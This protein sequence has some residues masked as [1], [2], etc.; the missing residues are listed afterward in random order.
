MAYFAIQVR[1][2]T[3]GRF[4]ALAQKKGF[5][6]PDAR[7]LWPRRRLRIRRAGAWLDSLAA[8]FPGYLFIQVDGIP[9]EL[10]SALRGTAGFLRFLRSNDDI[11]PMNRRDEDV[12]AHFLGF[13]EVVDRSVVF[14]DENRK[15]Q[16]LS[17]PLKGLEGRIIKVDRRKGRARVKLSLYE[18]SFAVDLGFELLEQAPAAAATPP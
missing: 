18:D 16:V 17:G 5:L 4:M 10:F 15:V 1:T 12:L 6:P 2:G 9:G 3:E 11:V 14:F 7:L 13:G 8:I